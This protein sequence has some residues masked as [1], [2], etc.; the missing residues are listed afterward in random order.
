[1]RRR[2]VL[3]KFDV[4][5]YA[6]DMLT[7]TCLS[8]RHNAFIGAPALACVSGEAPNSVLRNLLID[9]PYLSALSVERLV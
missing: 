7:I 9:R 3:L 1:M 6:N 8:L 4:G 2:R 5:A